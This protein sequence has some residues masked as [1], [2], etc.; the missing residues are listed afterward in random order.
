MASNRKDVELSLR[1][2][3]PGAENV[4]ALAGDVHALAG[5]GR[6]LESA[7][8]GGADKLAEFAAR[9]RELRAAEQS[10]AAELRQAKQAVAEQREAI[11]RAKAAYQAAGGDAAKYRQEL[12][13]MRLALVDAKAELRQKAEALAAAGAAAKGA[14]SAERAYADQVKA[15]AAQQA[16]ATAKVR[17]GLAG[18]QDDFRKL[19]ALAGAAIG[20]QLLGGFAGDLARTADAAANLTARIKLVTGEGAAFDS[21]WRGVFDVAQRTNTALETTG[22][23][24]TRIAKAGKDIGVTT[25][26]ALRL[27][28]TIN[29]ATQLSGASAE[30]A[31]AAITQLIQGLQSGVLRGDEFNSVMEQAP[32]LAQGL[33]D[34]LGLTTGEL[35]KMAEAG[36]LT[37]ATV[38]SALQG[39]SAALQAEFDKLPPTI[40]RALSNLSSAWTVYIGEADKAHGV[41]ATAAAAISALARNLDTVGAFLLSAGK[42][43]AAYKAVELAQTFLSQSAAISANTGVTAANTAATA[44][45]TAA[46]QANA[47]ATAAAGDAAAGGTTKLGAAISGL[48]TFALV[49]VLTNLREIGTAIG[50]GVAR[51]AGYGKAIDAAA[52][53]QRAEEEATRAAAAAKAA[54]AQRAQIA[55]DKL[56]GLSAE[57]RK[58]LDEFEGLRQKGEGAA[59]ALEKVTKSLRLDDIKGIADAGAA[60]DALALKGQISAR[61]VQESWTKA[62]KGIDLGVFEAQARAAFDGSEQGA[63]RLAAALDGATREAIARAG[64]DFQLI[65]GGMGEAAQSAINSLDLIVRRLDVL[66]AAGV[67]T[68]RALT[69]SIS[70]AIDSADSKRAIDAVRGQIE[71][72]RK[73]LGDKIADG[74]LDQAKQKALELKDAAD[75]AAPGINSIREAY[76]Q[77]GIQAPEDLARVAKANRD[78]W[79]LIKNDGTASAATVQQA[80]ARYAQSALDASGAAGTASRALTE[81]TLKAQAAAKGLAVEFDNTGRVIVR[82]AFEATAAVEKTTGAI[83][84]QSAALEKLYD[85]YRLV[86]DA[87]KTADGFAKGADGAA[88]GTFTN[89]LPVDQAFRL[90]DSVKNGQQSN[91]TVEEARAAFAQAEAAFKDMQAFTRQSPGSSSI[92]YQ[93]TTTAL[94]QAA[95]AALD[96][97]L[98]QSGQAQKLTGV[99]AAPQASGS[100]TVNINL[101]GRNASINVASQADSDALVGLLRQLESSQGTAA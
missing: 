35:R 14:A 100:R 99:A 77:L 6:Q 73:V 44:A 16:A 10:A 81:E 69:A 76:K 9:T 91:L 67:D 88:A 60:L 80:F 62:L 56:L 26:D 58:V 41:S 32:R 38:I 8:A 89:T 86:S 79:E 34:G 50:E 33:A 28:E 66:N 23:L 71:A 18:L 7:L 30:S 61:Q 64:L 5:E 57:G 31:N 13:A 24:F 84:E 59:E 40:G 11:D 17:D 42:A 54:L 98:S 85:R 29:Q 101:A 46:K 52:A 2:S 70:K 43:A 72:V 19:Q 87:S 83:K 25:A 68:G 4:D 53:Q 92:E 3:T 1:V 96:K 78:A 22:D 82:G 36:R 12:G 51:W 45:N 49:G 95:R 75:K 55:A 37:S 93:Q 21:A 20:G 97:V 39:Q 65:S 27:T 48:K 90:I 94:Y 15:S 47:A 74:F 63:R